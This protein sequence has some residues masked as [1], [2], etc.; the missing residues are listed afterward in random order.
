MK[1]HY[2]NELSQQFKK[3]SD[4]LMDYFLIGFFCAVFYLLLL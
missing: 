1:E 3:N 2:L 4:R